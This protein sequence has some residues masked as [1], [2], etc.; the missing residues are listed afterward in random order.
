MVHPNGHIGESDTDFTYYDHSNNT[1][2]KFN[3]ITLEGEITSRDPIDQPTNNLRDQLIPLLDA[4]V[5]KAYRT[6]KSKFNIHLDGE[7]LQIDL[8]CLNINLPSFWTGEWQCS[9]RL[10]DG[11]LSGQIKINCHYYE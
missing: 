6:P 3:P 11:V 4:Y 2:F 7:A 5:K 1:T 9:Y 8:S 10:E